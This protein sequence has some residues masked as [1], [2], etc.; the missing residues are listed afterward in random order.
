MD[1]DHVDVRHD[2]QR[3]IRQGRGVELELFEGRVQVLAGAFVFPGEAAAPPDIGPA[4]APAG[5]AGA[6]LEAEPGAFGVGL[7]RAVD[8]D[9]GAEVEEVLLG[10]L[11]FLE[12]YAIPLADKVVRSHHASWLGG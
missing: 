10:G 11:F 4:L 5:L 9:Q 1:A 2:Q 12:L 3:G 8:A 7:G 6:F